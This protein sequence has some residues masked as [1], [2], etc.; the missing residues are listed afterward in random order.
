MTSHTAILLFFATYFYRVL[1]TTVL[2]TGTGTVQT[3]R[4]ADTQTGRHAGP[5]HSV[6]WLVGWVSDTHMMVPVAERASEPT[7]AIQPACMPPTTN[8][9]D[10]VSQNV[11]GQQFSYQSTIE[12]HLTE[13]YPCALTCSLHLGTKTTEIKKITLTY[14]TYYS[15]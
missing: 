12:Y 14:N 9:C 6:G 3:R 5:P 15:I 4:H 8:N 7:Q 13:L 11:L 10:K 2:Y 1:L